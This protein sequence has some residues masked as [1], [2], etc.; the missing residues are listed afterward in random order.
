MLRWLCDD[1]TEDNAY[2]QVHLASE[3]SI[4][5]TTSASKSTTI[6]GQAGINRVSIPLE[7]GQGIRLQVVRGGASTVDL[8]PDWTYSSSTVRY[9]FSESPAGLMGGDR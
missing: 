7:A 2:A 5:L 4:I 9:N 1:Q 8:K 3:A 6:A